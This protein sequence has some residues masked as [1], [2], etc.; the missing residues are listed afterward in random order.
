M[1]GA[2]ILCLTYVPMI[3]AL[4]IR[5]PQKIKSWGDK[6]VL[7]GRKYEYERKFGRVKQSVVHSVAVALLAL[8][9]FSFYKNGWRVYSAIG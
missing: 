6:F 4:F 2:M 1:I 8:A 7:G 5:V 3:S 9:I